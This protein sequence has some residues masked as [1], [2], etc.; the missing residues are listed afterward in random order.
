[1]ERALFRY[2][3]IYPLLDDSL[4]P[5]EK[6]AL[7]KQILTKTYEIPHSNR[8]TICERTLRQYPSPSFG[9]SPLKRPK[10]DLSG[11]Q[12]LDNTDPGFE[13]SKIVT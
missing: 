3:L 13:N 2:G 7:R 10:I 5:G 8:T 11:S 1:M 9:K 4:S 12:S 6:T